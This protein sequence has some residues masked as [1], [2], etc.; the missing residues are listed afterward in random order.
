MTVIRSTPIVWSMA[1]DIG[2]HEGWNDTSL[3][4]GKAE[5]RR[6]EL[7]A[8]LKADGCI[9]FL[10]ICLLW[11]FLLLGIILF[12]ILPLL[13]FVSYILLKWCLGTRVANVVDEQVGLLATCYSFVNFSY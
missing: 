3:D 7:L 13:C 10:G 11:W 12:L 6:C 9:P 2:C 8:L 1:L 4:I 5:G